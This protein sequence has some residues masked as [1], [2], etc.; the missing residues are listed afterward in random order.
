VIFFA[1]LGCV[2]HFK[3]EL[4]QNWLKIDQDSAERT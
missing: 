1:I 3:G 4:R 2:T